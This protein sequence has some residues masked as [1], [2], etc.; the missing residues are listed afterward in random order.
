M[1]DAKREETYEKMLA[2]EK[3]ALKKLAAESKG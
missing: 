3:E 1:K 2:E